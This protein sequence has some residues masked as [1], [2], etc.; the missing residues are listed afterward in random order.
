MLRFLKPL[1]AALVALAITF[2]QA[3]DSLL[4]LFAVLAFTTVLV[5][6][7]IIDAIRNADRQLR[8]TVIRI[9]ASILVIGSLASYSYMQEQDGYTLFIINVAI[10]AYGFAVIEMF[11]S[12]KSGLVKTIDGRDHLVVAVIHFSMLVVYLLD[13]ARLIKLGEV[14]AVGIYGAYTAILAVL[15]GIK[16]FDPKQSS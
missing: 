12:A 15:W 7:E 6:V 9:A 4:G 13:F 3:H 5:V 1:S 14:P 8:A 11:R 10:A 2:T 16:A